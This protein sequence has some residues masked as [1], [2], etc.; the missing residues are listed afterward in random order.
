MSPFTQLFR[1]LW[2]NALWW[3]VPLVLLLFVLFLFVWLTT[4]PNDMPNIY[5]RP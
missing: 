2:T 5:Q 4:D 1:Y 3:L